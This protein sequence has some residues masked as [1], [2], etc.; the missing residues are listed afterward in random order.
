[1][2]DEL[3]KLR[4]YARRCSIEMMK[5]SGGGSEMFERIGEDFYATPE[6]CVERTRHKIETIR[7]LRAA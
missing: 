1:M 3:T 6:L 5:L 7:K 2:S 4:S